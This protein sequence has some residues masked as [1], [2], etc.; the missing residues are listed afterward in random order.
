MKIALVHDWL[1]NMGGAEQCVLNFMDVYPEAPIY[2][3]MF[4][5][6]NVDERFSAKKVVTTFL[7]RFVKKGHQKLFPLMPLA[8]ERLDLT[9]FDVVLSSTSCCA[10]GII[11][12]PNCEHFC[13]CH[14]PIRYV[15]ARSF[16][17]MQGMGKIKRF[18]C[19]I[20]LHYMRLWDFSAAQRV[21]H[22]IANSTEVQRR[23]KK[24]Y[25]RDSVVIFPP[26]RCSLFSMSDT[27]GDYFLVVSRLVYYKRFDL[28]VK[29]CTK[30][31]KKLI[32]IGDGPER[33][34][35]E[36]MA[37]PT[38]QFLGRQPDEVVQ[39][40][41]AECKA[42]LFPGEDDFGIVPVEAEACGRPVI[43]YGMGGALDT[44]VPGKTGVLFYEQTEES[45][46]EAIEKFESMNFDKQ[47]IRNH[48][49]KFDES[50]FKRQIETYISETIKSHKIKT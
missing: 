4:V 25:N 41:M 18:L 44:V 21:D 17:Y 29:A 7:Q 19:S 43:A 1:T 49:L 12:G 33:K 36:A 24:Y 42:L 34:N 46:A 2:T 38:V 10:K 3:S 31:G 45:I 32:V 27:D 8:F 28:A 15:W 37:G 13:Y 35:L 47:E 22:F 9:D 40:H 50:E 26:V 48:A 5:K 11:S 20:L 23:I 39:K 14:T 30:L 16:E 6:D